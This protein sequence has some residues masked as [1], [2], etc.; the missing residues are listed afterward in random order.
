MNKTEKYYNII[1]EGLN[2]NSEK[3]IGQFRIDIN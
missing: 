3:I 1:M 2:K